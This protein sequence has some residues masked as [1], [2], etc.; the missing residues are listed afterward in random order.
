MAMNSTSTVGITDETL[1]NLL[2]DAGAVYLDYGTETEA[3]L[4]CCSG[5]SEFSV[6][7]KY[8]SIS[9]NGVMSST[10]GLNFKI[11][12]EVTLKVS[13]LEV[14][15]ATLQMA[16]NANVDSTGLEADILTGGANGKLKYLINVA[17]VTRISGNQQPIVIILK[18]AINLD[19]LKLKTE[20]QKDNLL[21]VTFT[22]NL[23]L[24]DLN[25]S[26]YEI[27]YPKV[28]V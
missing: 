25:G 19:G 26:A 18:N 27:H 9:A 14:T 10:K 3:L 11:S 16:L 5:A 7:P 1:N 21:P 8:R 4:G 6:I 13:L 15:A 17:L 2:L 22:A 20:D 12:E 28:Q 24:N 23:D